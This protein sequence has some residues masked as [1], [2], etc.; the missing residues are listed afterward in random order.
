MP[1][2]GAIGPSSTCSSSHS[3]TV[4]SSSSLDQDSDL[5]MLPFPLDFASTA[6]TCMPAPEMDYPCD[7]K[8]WNNGNMDAWNTARD[9][10]F[11]MSY[12][13]RT[14]LPYY[15]KLAESFTI[16]D[17]YFQ[18][19]FTATCPNR[20]HLFSGSNGLSAEN[21]SL[22]LL[23]DDEPAGMNWETMGETLENAGVSWKLYQGQDNFDDNGFA[24]FENYKNSKEGK[25][26][27][28]KGIAIQDDF[29][30][31]FADDVA[32]GTL[33]QVS[34]L[35]APA[36]LSEHATNHPADG[37]DLSSRLI[38]VL[39]SN[40]EMYKKTAFIL[41]YDEGGLFPQ[42]LSLS[43]SSVSFSSACF[44]SACFSLN[45]FVSDLCVRGRPILRRKQAPQSAVQLMLC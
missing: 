34:W 29:V 36:W 30:R 14:E 4:P 37:E 15:Y 6:A 5:Y 8:I 28:D 3:V 33:P 1:I 26:L 31:S 22:N 12:F 24:W 20:E 10:G 16:G 27:F 45:R 13:N 35:V 17:Q 11:G 2:S 23:D 43:F 41:N 42:L 21:T 25:P 32:N 18:S 9:P 44:S 39:Q 19:T 38:Q 7:I 40:P